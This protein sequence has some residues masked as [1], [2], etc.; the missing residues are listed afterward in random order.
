MLEVA[1][2]T[3]TSST[4]AAPQTF[5]TPVIAKEAFGAPDS[6]GFTPVTLKGAASP[7]FVAAA[8]PPWL[9]KMSGFDCCKDCECFVTPIVAAW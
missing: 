6:P 1:S 7:V 3:L 9:A 5:L 4:G 8:A 2:G